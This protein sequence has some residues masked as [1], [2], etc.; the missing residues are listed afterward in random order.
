MTVKSKSEEAISL[1]SD[2]REGMFDVFLFEFTKC[3]KDLGFV[4]NLLTISDIY[5]L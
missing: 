5:W 4:R 2:I 1:L 3:Q